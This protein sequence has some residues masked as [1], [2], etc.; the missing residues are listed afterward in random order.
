VSEPQARTFIHEGQDGRYLLGGTWYFRQDEQN[1]G[2][3]SRFFAQRSL[4]GWSAVGVPNNWN[5]RDFTQNLPSVGWYRKEFKLPRA[6][7]LRPPEPVRGKKKNRRRPPPPSTCN[8]FRWKARFIGANHRASVWLNGRPVGGHT[9]GYFPFELRLDGLR[10]GRNTLVVRVSTY[11]GRTDLTHWRLA[12]PTG[13]GTG[14]WWNF[15]GLSREVYLRRIDGI[16]IESLKVLPRQRCTRC[17]ARVEVTMRVRHLGAEKR[18]VALT[19]LLGAGNTR[20][21]ITLPARFFAPG[22]VRDIRAFFTIE[23]PRLWWPRRPQLYRLA[24]VAA[25]DDQRSV[26]RAAFGVKRLQVLPD[27][28]VLLNGRPLQLR[29]ASIHEDDPRVGAAWGP[30]ERTEALRNLRQLGATVT[31]AHYPLHPAML[32]A[33][34][35]AGILVWNQAPVYQLPNALLDQ[36]RVRGAA[37]RANRETVEANV[38][39]ASIFAWSI[40]NELGSEPSELGAV[41]P[42]QSTFILDAIQLIKRLDDTRLVAMDRHMRLGEPPYYPALTRLDALGLN[43]YF[44]WYKASAA[45]LPESTSDELLPHLDGVHQQLPGLPIFITEFGAEASRDGPETDKGTYDFQRKW[46]TDHA[47][48]HGAR[49]YI[50]GSIA[51]ALK[52]FRVHPAW[53][54]GNPVPNPPWNNKGLIHEQGS[55]KPAFWELRARF[56]RTAGLR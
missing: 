17:A 15:G 18:R 39:H 32:E 30:S 8:R 37:L 14:G 42:G 44:G 1:V 23:R 51:W 36:P 6:L 25:A 21:T 56:R 19:L 22:E 54:G 3:G 7:C 13:Y 29:G 49:P 28:R 38:N 35:R 20:R 31:R 5:A 55:P 45:G 9:G 47:A 41:G 40:A 33:L 26:Y 10:P 48:L 11:R 43:D 46:M 34:D 27:G 53:G 4:A 12:G 2:L 24:A 52:D 50:N 16:D